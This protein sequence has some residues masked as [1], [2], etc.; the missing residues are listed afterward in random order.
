[1]LFKRGPLSALGGYLKYFGLFLFQDLHQMVSSVLYYPE[2]SFARARE[3]MR[4]EADWDVLNLSERHC[5][6]VNPFE[7]LSSNSPSSVL[8]K[9]ITYS[10]NLQ[11]DYQRFYLASIPPLRKASVTKRMPNYTQRGLTIPR[12][13]TVT[14][15]EN[16]GSSVIGDFAGLKAGRWPKLH[17]NNLR[18]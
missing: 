13:A 15:E 17:K 11:F 4:S 9:R 18:S 3:G 7:V 1:M 6:T 12:L 10:A 16:E 5:A 14:S 8:I 2:C